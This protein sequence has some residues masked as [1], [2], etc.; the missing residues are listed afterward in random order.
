VILVQFFDTE[1]II[2]DF[3]QEKFL[4]YLAINEFIHF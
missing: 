1:C 4:D 3:P 2:C